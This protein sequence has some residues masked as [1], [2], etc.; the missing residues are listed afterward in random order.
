MNGYRKK[1][2]KEGGNLS[3]CKPYISSDSKNAIAVNSG[4]IE[5]MIIDGVQI[6]SIDVNRFAKAVNPDYNSYDGWDDLH[7]AM[8][9]NIKE[10][11]CSD[12]PWFEECEAMD[13]PDG[14]YD[15]NYMDD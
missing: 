3:W 14:W 6:N 8:E 4:K 12:C 15:E 11:A 5:G 9:G 7:I 1:M 10:S 2:L 13:N